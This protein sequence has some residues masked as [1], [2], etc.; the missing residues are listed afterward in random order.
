M[1]SL[2]PKV[3]GMLAAGALASVVLPQFLNEREDVSLKSYLD[4]SGVW[5]YCRG[6]T[7]G[8]K[9]GMRFTAAQCAVLDKK[10]SDRALEEVNKFIKV[11][12]T[13]PQ[14]VGVASF[15]AYNIGMT[16]CRGST[17]FR[18]INAGD[19]TGACAQISRWV[20]D[21]GKDC[22]LTKGEPN[23]C[24]GQVERRAAERELCEMGITK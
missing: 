4:G 9:Q 17:F 2:S 8:G 15:C 11:P 16:Q 3:K 14:K 7:A 1:S 13:E 10:A 24:Y 6:L 18:L 5:T 23:G 19:M 22:R 12:L 21:G 20:H